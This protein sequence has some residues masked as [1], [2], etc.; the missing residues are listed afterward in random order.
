MALSG[1]INGSTDNQYI[2]SKI[3]WSATQSIDGNYSMVTATLY[4]SRNNTGFTTSGTWS[5]SITINGTTKSDSG[6][7]SITYNSN[8][9]AITNT[10]KVPHNTD[11]TK[12][13]TISATGSI[14]GTTLSGTSVSSS[15]TLNTIPRAATLNSLTC[16]TSYLDGTFTYKYTPTTTSYYIRGNLSL[17]LNGTFISINSDKNGKPSSTSQQTKT[18]KLTSEQLEKIY[19]ELPSSTSATIRLTLRTY[20][21]SAYTQQVGDYSY[22]EVKLTIPE[23]V[24]PTVGNIALTP[25]NVTING[26]SYTY[27]IKGKNKLSLSVTDSKAGSGSSIKSY[28]FSGPSL[29]KTQTSASVSVST[30]TNVNSFT[31]GQATLTYTVIATD[32]RNRSS[33]PKTQT[34]TCYDYQNPSFSSF[35]ATRSGTTLT[36]TYTPM[37]SSIG[38]KNVANVEIYYITGKTESIKKVD[39]VASGQNIDTAITLDN[40]VSTYKVYAVIIDGLGVENQTSTKTVYGDSRVMNVTADGTGIAFGKMAETNNMLECKWP[41]VTGSR[42][43]CSGAYGDQNFNIYCQWADGANHDILVRGTDGLSVGLGWVG[44]DEY[45]TSLDIRPKKVNIRGTVT[46]P[47]GRFTASTDANSTSQEDVALRVGDPEYHH[48]DMDVNEI[49]AKKGKTELA[50]L[51]LVGSALGLYSGDNL[52]MTIGEDSTGAYVQSMP[53]YNRTSS[54]S[55]NM[56]VTS[57]GTFCRTTSS[58]ERYKTEIADVANEELDPYKILDIPVRQFK[59]TEDNVPIDRQLDDTYIG[60]IAEEVNKAYPAATE[61][62]EDG[63]IEMWNIKV[64]FPALLKIVQDQQKEII[65]LK[66]KV[67]DLQD[68]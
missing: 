37:F 18:V 27:L 62:T 55:P 63:Q 52:S 66:K 49:I 25:T 28:T 53:V 64:L 48:I 38:G 60:L 43:G 6:Y 23:S 33:S 15:V 65:K 47:R 14:S 2:D 22:K 39:G 59:Y 51:Y 19:K 42:F 67:E 34:I 45:E 50:E 24:K 54:G 61:Y 68:E 11:G 57:Y 26:T 29:S 12:T 8:T 5:G 56:Y 10:V 20:S 21:D 1:T 9:K 41:I 58:S 3:E 46:A 32:T 36:C 35:K 7:L 40:S 16:S 44:N 17:N 4:Y 31:N 13:I 30:V